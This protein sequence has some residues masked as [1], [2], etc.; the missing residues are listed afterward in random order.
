MKFEIGT[1][2]I[3]WNCDRH[4]VE[5]VILSKYVA[6]YDQMWKWMVE[7]LSKFQHFQGRGIKIDRVNSNLV[8]KSMIFIIAP[9]VTWSW[10][11]A[12]FALSFRLLT[13]VYILWSQSGINIQ[14]GSHSQELI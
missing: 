3:L 1:V 6:E 12:F 13:F 5:P 10:A 9:W 8:A 7:Y 2:A 14:S 4:S 11:I